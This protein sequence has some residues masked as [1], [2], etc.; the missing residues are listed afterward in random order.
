MQMNAN[1]AAVIGSAAQIALI[2]VFLVAVLSKILTH[3]ELGRTIARLGPAALARPATIAVISAELLAV[4]G[5]AVRA[6]ALIHSVPVRRID[7]M[8]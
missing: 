3:H 8:V 6:P 1:T 5:L 2:M 4:I 7:Q